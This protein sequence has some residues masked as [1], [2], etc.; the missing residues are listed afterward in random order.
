MQVFAYLFT[1]GHS[2]EDFLVHVAWMTGDEPNAMESGKLIGFGEQIRKTVVTVS[3]GIDILAQKSHLPA[4]LNHQSPD[5][6]Q[7]MLQG[8][9]PGRAAKGGNNAVATAIIA[10][11]HQKGWCIG[12]GLLG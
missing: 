9:T 11:P 5:L 2:P 12:T 7:N 8:T 6:L 10:A 3:I 1:G 4:A